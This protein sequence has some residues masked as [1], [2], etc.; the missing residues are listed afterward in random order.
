MV[1]AQA[2][3]FEKTYRS[4]FGQD[5]EPLGGINTDALER[6][7]KD[8][9]RSLK[10]MDN[11]GEPAPKTDYEQAQTSLPD[12]DSVQETSGEDGY[13]ELNEINKV[14][15]D[16]EKGVFDETSQDV[17]SQKTDKTADIY[18]DFSWLYE[19]SEK[20]DGPAP[21]FKDPKEEEELKSLIDD[22]ID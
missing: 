22:I 19:T 10:D 1:N 14:L 15:N 20:Q 8:M 7:D 2:A 5:S 13:M 21:V 11:S 12:Q 6:I 3:Y 4:Y 17:S 16:I 18:G 9:E